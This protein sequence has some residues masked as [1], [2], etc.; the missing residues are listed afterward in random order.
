[1]VERNRQSGIDIFSIAGILMAA[2]GI[3]LFAAMFQSSRA[4]SLGLSHRFYIIITH[5]LLVFQLA[6]AVL[7]FGI[8][9]ILRNLRN[10]VSVDPRQSHKAPPPGAV[11]LLLDLASAALISGSMIV[12]LYLL[13]ESFS[14]LDVTGKW[15]LMIGIGNLLYSLIFALAGSS[16]KKMLMEGGPATM[17]RSETASTH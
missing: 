12:L 7:F 1:M 5:G 9:K 10:E 4:G 13:P 16:I 2:A 6:F 8:G 17:G 3:A 11:E 14:K 15:L